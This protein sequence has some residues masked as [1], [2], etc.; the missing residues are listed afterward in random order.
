MFP[1]MTQDL[2]GVINPPIPYASGLIAVPCV[3][4]SGLAVVDRRV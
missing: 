2:I 4:V 1:P 3:T